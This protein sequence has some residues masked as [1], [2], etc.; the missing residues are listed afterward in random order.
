MG[1]MMVKLKRLEVEGGFLNGVDLQFAEGLNVLIGARG[2]GKTSVIELL[3]YCLDV[4]AVTERAQQEAEG[5]ALWVLGDEGCATLTI[6]VD[7]TEHVLR[8]GLNQERDTALPKTGVLFVSQ[9]EIEEIGRDSGSRRRILDDA[10]A[11][12][13]APLVAGALE[14]AVEKAA[15]ALHSQRAE[16]DDVV[17][18]LAGLAEVPEQ[19]KAAQK[20]Q[21]ENKTQSDELVKLQKQASSLSDEL[22]DMGAQAE[23]LATGS[24]RASSWRA[25][26]VAVRSNEPDFSRLPKEAADAVGKDI[27]AARQRIDEALQE[28][29]KIEESLTAQHREATARLKAKRREL[30][31]VSSKIDVFE[32]GAGKISRR[33]SAL[34][35]Q[36]KHRSHLLERQKQL[37]KQIKSSSEAR[38]EALNDLSGIVDKRYA[39]R[40]ETAEALNEKFGPEIRVDVIKAG[41]VSDYE[42]ALGEALQGSNLQWRDLAKRVSER[43]SPRELIAA[44]ER[45]DAKAVENGAA[46]SEDR[47]KRLVSHLAGVDTTEIV[48]AQIDEGVDFNLLDGTEM[49]ATDRLSLGQRCTVV[50]PLLLARDPDLAV[51]DQPED[52]LDNAFIVETV[53]DVL[54]SRR[55]GA[56][57][58]IATHNANI[59]VLGEADHVFVM[60]SSGSEAYVPT[61]GELD[62]DDVREAITKLM[63]GGEE[64]FRR[65][66]EFYGK[67]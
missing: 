27:M 43:M 49:K 22:G 33:V 30:A 35:E 6:E 16:L 39:R 26:L 42:R 52:H 2:S 9:Q 21:Q 28:L 55:E 48:L 47:A 4:R 10:A 25:D 38:T 63:E 62:D 20:E 31:E 45:L 17:Q 57:R 18:R 29:A 36:D 56:Q 41:E 1:T 61:N 60:S 53:V 15:Q 64:A 19:L 54:R 67:K 46:I 13:Q 32:E 50:L 65:R 66:A 58:L 24:A 23:A 51:L 12:E 3:R 5:Q 11:D 14:D 37:E 8:R 34:R 40:R 7:G 44:V 59:P